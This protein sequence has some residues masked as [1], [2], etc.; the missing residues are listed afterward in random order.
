L[1]F[2]DPGFASDYFIGKN[3]RLPD[4]EWFLL[5]GKEL[6][7]AKKRL[8]KHIDLGMAGGPAF[9]ASLIMPDL[10]IGNVLYAADR[11]VTICC[12]MLAPADGFSTVNGPPLN[13]T[14]H[15]GDRMRVTTYRNVEF[16][17][18]ELRSLQW[19]VNA[20]LPEGDAYL[21]I[22]PL[23]FGEHIIYESCLFKAKYDYTNSSMLFS[24]EEEATTDFPVRNIGINA[25]AAVNRRVDGRL[26]L[27]VRCPV[28]YRR[29]TTDAKRSIIARFA[30]HPD[31]ALQ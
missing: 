29:V 9:R 3:N 19:Y 17:G 5:G 6:F 25:D 22:K 26:A 20:R 11:D 7:I 21:M 30:H 27:Y 28:E 18:A 8:S 12:S 2:I 10:F 31:D 14:V 15:D 13:K 23:A 16:P 1:G 4:G 24:K